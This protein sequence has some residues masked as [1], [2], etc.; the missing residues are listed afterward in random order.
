[1]KTIVMQD[2]VTQAALQVAYQSRFAPRGRLSRLETAI[3]QLNHWVIDKYRQG[4]ERGLAN[5]A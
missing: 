1:M 4:L 2:Q 5:P 3:T